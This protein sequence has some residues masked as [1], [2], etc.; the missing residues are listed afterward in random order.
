MS[1]SSTTDEASASSSLC[2]VCKKSEFKYTCPACSVK[3]CSLACV[4][5]HKANSK[6][7]GKRALVE[8]VAINEFDE[9][10]L[11]RDISLLED[12]SCKAHTA[13]T[14]SLETRNDSVVRKGGGGR[15]VV[16]RLIEILGR[17]SGTLR[18]I[19]KLRDFLSKRS[20]L[21]TLHLVPDLFQLAKRNSSCL[22]YP[23]G[24][25]KSKKG[26]QQQ[27]QQPEKT[28]EPNADAG[29]ADP[30]ATKGESTLAPQEPR[31]EPVV[32]WKLEWRFQPAKEGG[33]EV[34]LNEVCSE[35]AKSGD[36]IEALVG[37]RWRRDLADS[38][39]DYIAAGTEKV[40]VFMKVLMSH[41]PHTYH[42]E[43][44]YNNTE[45][46][47]SRC[48][49]FWLLDASKSIK[50]N[51]Y[52][53]VVVEHPVFIV[54]LD[55]SKFPVMVEEPQPIKE[56]EEP[57]AEPVDE[58]AAVEGPTFPVDLPPPAPSKGGWPHH[59]GKGRSS[60][61]GQWSGHPGGS[62]GWQ[63]YSG[64]G[65][66]WWSAGKGGK[67]ADNWAWGPQYSQPQ[68]NWQGGNRGRREMTTCSIQVARG[69]L[70]GMAQR[71]IAPRAKAATGVKGKVAVTTI[72]E[73]KEETGDTDDQRFPPPERLSL[74]RLFLHI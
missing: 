22:K 73:V 68:S 16:I 64:D 74:K 72:T 69:T 45:Q 6:C 46:D 31:Q 35:D 30:E 18:D 28:E 53:R 71:G 15:Q 49:K 23:G 39:P 50:E 57:A 34:V 54:T 44:P 25:P 9:K 47:L 4:N 42:D 36:L 67:G 11:R 65:S 21:T 5:A 29:K 1:G 37:N 7:T 10:V 41:K 2:Q 26:E 19:R 52:Y 51:L 43:S 24:K 62:K 63:D 66:G 3:T 32:H 48:N 38:I 12:A 55:A 60:G 14:H 13:Q 59:S 20:P 17:S 33:E 8:H 61:K 70:S 56:V 27:Q 40:S 58:P